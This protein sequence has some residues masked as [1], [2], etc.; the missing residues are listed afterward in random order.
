[1]K[2]QE[3]FKVRKYTHE[4]I[5]KTV[6]P[7]TAGL[8]PPRRATTNVRQRP[9]VPKLS[10]MESSQ[11]RFNSSQQ[12]FNTKETRDVYVPNMSNAF[13]ASGF[14]MV[15]ANQGHL[16]HF[17]GKHDITTENGNGPDEA[18]RELYETGGAFDRTQYLLKRL[19]T[20]TPQ[21]VNVNRSKLQEIAAKTEDKVSYVYKNKFCG[22]YTELQRAG[23]LKKDDSWDKF[24]NPDKI[25]MDNHMQ[26]AL[27]SSNADQLRSKQN[28]GGEDDDATP[29]P[30]AKGKNKKAAEDLT[31]SSRNK[32][33]KPKFRNEL[34]RFHYQF[35]TEKAHNITDRE[36]QER[37]ATDNKRFEAVMRKAKPALRLHNLL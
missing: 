8:P 9:K 20:V 29:V 24:V 31:D 16:E 14:K 13:F 34:E 35:E 21:V 18:V 26:K 11:E 32:A 5:H 37:L 23:K 10:S 22:I 12:R 3:V 7:K 17:L 2:T 1:M 27:N 33:A 25:G 19:R 4:N 28:S 15:D 36:T 6:G 30:A